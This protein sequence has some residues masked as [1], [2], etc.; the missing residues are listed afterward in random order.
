[1]PAVTVFQAVPVPT[2]FGECRSVTVPSPSCPTLL[3]PQHQSDPLVSVPQV[4]YMPAVT[5]FQAVPVPTRIGEC[6]SVTVPSP[7]CPTMLFPQHQ[8]EWSLLTAQ[9]WVDPLETESHSVYAVLGSAPVAPPKDAADASATGASTAATNAMTRARDTAPARRAHLQTMCSLRVS[10]TRDVSD[11]DLWW[12]STRT[13]ARSF[14][15]A[16]CEHRREGARPAA[17]RVRTGRGS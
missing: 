13:V 14:L 12:D 5:V 3:L 8:S 7:S 2:R 4:W 15:S 10:P 1:M 9:V 17:C 6:R 16:G 11:V